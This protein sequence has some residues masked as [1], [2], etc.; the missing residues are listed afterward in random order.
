M[1]TGGLMDKF[2]VDFT[3][4]EN[5]FK[6]KERIKLADVEDQIEKVAFGVVRFNNNVKTGLWEIVD[7]EDGNKYIAAMYDTD[8]KPTTGDWS[9]ESDK[10]NKSATI[11]Y[12]NTPIT[13]LAFNEIGINEEDVPDFKK[14][15][16]TKLAS[17]S[18]LVNK[19]L[20]DLPSEY[21]SKIVNL[22]PEL[23]QKK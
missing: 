2:T 20:S 5:H 17:N 6:S 3:E 19:M 7:G 13:S 9:V 1:D 10:M 12:K 21:K 4:I 8:Q 14:A 23:A 11:F 18:D 16:P 15:L 22:Y